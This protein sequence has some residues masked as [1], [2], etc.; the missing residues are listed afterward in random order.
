MPVRNSPISSAFIG[1]L[2]CAVASF[3]L[4]FVLTRLDSTRTGEAIGYGLI[5]AVVGALIGFAI[6]LT[7]GSTKVGVLG[8]GLIGLIGTVLA[9]AGFIALF[10]GGDPLRALR[11]NW[12]ALALVVGPPS[13]VTGLLTAWIKNRR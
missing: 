4:F 12:R 2:I 9:F 10:G 6:G 8:G 3:G 1:A 13:L 7:I 5:V 11:S